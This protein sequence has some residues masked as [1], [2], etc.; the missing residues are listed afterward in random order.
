MSTAGVDG[1]DVRLETD[2]LVLRPWR[3]D[4]ADVVREMWAERDPRVP[5][6]RRISIDGHPTVEE[7][8]D[9]IRA[10]P[11][12]TV[13][14]LAIERKAERDVVGSCGL[15]DSGRGA[16]G[17]P[18]IAFELLRRAQR[19]GYA[20]E[21]ALAVLQWARGSGHHRLWATVWD[22]NTASLRVLAKVGFTRTDRI[23]VDAA[24]GTTLFLTRT[25]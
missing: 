23:E 16:P 14:L 12:T 24:R 20:T 4:E 15:V 21:A 6:H 10:S 13:G 11:P 9:R 1:G 7:L 5:P 22:W 19:T 17:E 25:L 8:E 2:R 3:V 18:E